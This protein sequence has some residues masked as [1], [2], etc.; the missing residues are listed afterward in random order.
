MQGGSRCLESTEKLVK[1]Q[2]IK[3]FLL[4]AERFFPI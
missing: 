3:L 4:F 1:C 2:L